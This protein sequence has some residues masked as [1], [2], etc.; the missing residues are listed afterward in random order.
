MEPHKNNFQDRFLDILRKEKIPLSIFLTNGIRLQGKIDAFDPYIVLLKNDGVLQAVYKHAISTIV[1][2][3]AVAL[4]AEN[5][6]PEV[7][8]KRRTPFGLRRVDDRPDDMDSS[9]NGNR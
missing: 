9:V 3:R 7:V 5:A 4:D 6:T 2:S 8:V 1:P